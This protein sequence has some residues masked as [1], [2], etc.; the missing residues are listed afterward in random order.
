MFTEHNAN[1]AGYEFNAMKPPALVNETD[2]TVSG[3]TVEV[4][5]DELLLDSWDI[6]EALLYPINK[7]PD[8][9][10]AGTFKTPAPGIPYVKEISE[11]SVEPDRVKTVLGVPKNVPPPDDPVGPA[12]P[13]G[14][15]APDA[16]TDVPCIPCGPKAPSIPRGPVA[17]VGPALDPPAGPTGPGTPG[18]PTDN[19]VGPTGPRAPCGPGCPTAAPK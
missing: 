7:S 17:P 19:P 16:P 5:E 1:R 3:V 11:Y 6:R 15:V 12:E 9:D 2:V 10:I 18:R 8:T 13:V 4:L 14:P